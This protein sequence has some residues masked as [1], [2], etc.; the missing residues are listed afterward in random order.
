MS[1]YKTIP[2]TNLPSWHTYY[3]VNGNV[4]IYDI[5]PKLYIY[6]GV[7]SETIL[8]M[9][10]ANG[11][12]ITL[13]KISLSLM[14]SCYSKLRDFHYN[15]GSENN[16]YNL[17]GTIPSWK[18]KIYTVSG[19][20]KVNISRDKNHLFIGST[21][22]HPSDFR[23]GVIPKTLLIRMQGGGGGGG[24]VNL[25]SSRDFGGAE[26]INVS[27][28]GGSGAYISLVLTFPDDQNDYFELR[29][30]SGGEHNEDGED[31]LIRQYHSPSFINVARAGGGTKGRYSSTTKT[32]Y[33][34]VNS[35]YGGTAIIHS[36]DLV[37]VLE[38]TRGF[39]GGYGALNPSRPYTGNIG[40]SSIDC[41][42]KV[43]A[44]I[45]TDAF[46]KE[47]VSKKGGYG[48][49]TSIGYFNNIGTA[50]VYCGGGGASVDGIGGNVTPDYNPGAGILG[51]GGAGGAVYEADSYDEM[52]GDTYTNLYSN[53]GGRGG[54]G[55]IE[56]YY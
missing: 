14:S 38:S 45:D 19:G 56:I 46:K 33:F 35:G 49:L 5:F 44:S 15:M 37:N 52:T 3:N 8:N 47:T 10:D 16:E 42:N 22:F 29:A 11:I 50:N 32:T 18:Y 20:S 24:G 51:S 26:T 9:Y 43:F 23:D 36:Q 21:T 34:T 2:G 40:G 48:D 4:D 13:P 1:N 53:A 55:F 31:S 6:E 12:L 7:T 17:S 27:S 30:G 54:D 25:V 39:D 41:T 28:G